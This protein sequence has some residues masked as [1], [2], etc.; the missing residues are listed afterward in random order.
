MA[1]TSAQPA[2]AEVSRAWRAWVALLVP[3][4]SLAGTFAVAALW[5]VGARGVAGFEVAAALQAAPALPAGLGF[6]AAF[7]AARA[8]ARRDGLSLAELGWR[9]P[10]PA[11]LA[12]AAAVAAAVWAAN[13]LLLYPLL[14]SA[15]P[16]FD[17]G[18][19]GVP[20][21]PTVAML[22]LGVAAEETVYRGFA[23]RRLAERH[24]AWAAAAITS[25]AYAALAPGP[26][27]P[28]KAWAL[29]FGLVL[30]AL[31]HLRG[32]LWAVALAHAVVSLGPALA[33][34]L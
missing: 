9:R 18:L 11:D 15:Q 1:S 13:A 28:L 5:L 34:R 27:L 32:N 10:A 22:T 4:L 7:L 26:E 19:P 17:P 3:P 20:L 21:G 30:A 2:N 24:G 12:W 29:G 33:A 25:V 31:R 14:R 6:A 23:F 16:S 8:L